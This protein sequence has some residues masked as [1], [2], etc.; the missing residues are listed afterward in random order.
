MNTDYRPTNSWDF[1][2][3]AAKVG[4]VRVRSLAALSLTVALIALLATLATF[5]A[6][7][8]QAQSLIG[9]VDNA[10]QIASSDSDDFQAQSFETG[11]NVGGYTVSQVQIQLDDVSGKSTSVKIRQDDGGEPGNLVATL[12]NPGTL[13]SYQFNTFTAQPVITLAASTTYWITVNEGI[14]SDR[15]PVLNTSGD[16]DSSVWGW[17]IGDDRLYRTSEMDPWSESTRSLLIRIWGTISTDAKL[18]SLTLEGADGGETIAL[19]PAFATG[20]Y[21]YTAAV[22]NR[23]DAVKLTATKND[24]NATV[25]ITNDDDP[26][27][28]EEALLD[29]SVGSNTLTVTVTAQDGTPLTYTINVE[30][31]TTTT[32]LVSNT[33]LSASASTTSFTAQS[34]ETGANTGGYTVSEVDMRLGLASGR[35]ASV[36]IREN[37]ADNEPGDLVATLTNPGTL[38]D[39]SLNTFTAPAGTTLAASTTYWITVNEGISSNRAS[40]DYAEGNG[41]TGETGWS[42]GDDRLSRINETDSWHTATSSL[43][44]TIKGTAVPATTLV[45][46]THLTPLGN[47]GDYEAQ[48]FETGTNA[49]GYTVSGIDMQLG[50]ASGYSTTVKIRENNADNEPGDLVATLTN[51]GTLTDNSLN[52]FTAPAG[53]RLDASTTYW[54]SVNE[55]IPTVSAAVFE[56]S[57]GNAETGEAGWTIGDSRLTRVDETGSWQTDGD[58][59]LITIKGTAVPTTTLVSNTHLSASLDTVHFQAQ[60]FETGANPD[61]Y[62]V[63]EVD[64]R[65]GIV[66]SRSTSVKIRQDD[67]GEPGDL[68]ATLTNPASLKS[69]RLNTFTAPAGTTLAASTTYWITVNEGLYILDSRAIVQANAGNDQTGETGW[70][71]GNDRL[72]R[73]VET[74]EWQTSTSSLLMTIKGTAVPCDGIWCATL[75]VQGLGSGHR[76]CG[77]SSTGNE[78]SNAA[79]L[80]EDEFTHASTPYSVTAARVQSG[81]QLQL[82]L[83]PDITTDSQTLVL[84]VGSETFSFEDATMKEANHRKWNNSGLSWTTGD[85]VQLRLTDSQTNLS[86]SPTISGTPQVGQVLT[87]DISTIDDVDGLPDTFEYQWVRV[88]SDDTKTNLGTNSTHT[89]TSSDVGSTIRVDVSYTDLAGNSEGPLPS[90]ATAA[91]VPAAGLC[92]PNNDWCA[93]MTVTVGKYVGTNT[94]YGFKER[95]FGQLDEPTIDYGPSFEV[96]EIFISEPDSSSFDDLVYVTLDAY[97]PLGTVFNLGG[98]DFT[99]K[100]RQQNQFRHPFLDPPRGLRLDRWPGSHGQREPGPGSG[101]RHRGRDNA[102]HHPFRGPQHGLGPDDKRVHREGGRQRNDAIER[103]GR[104]QDG[105]AHPD[106]AGHPRRDGHGQIPCASEQSLTGHIGPGGA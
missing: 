53:T 76:G 81:G 82:Y 11:A 21:A 98:T 70:S 5:L 101:E 25:V 91:V 95:F 40:V 34:F 104:H 59:L 18:K 83:S 49:G 63:S 39:N 19:S 37:N 8:L 90:E 75:T 6:T 45:S 72:L 32:T 105:D 99:A 33:H 92:P 20:K 50:F 58:S 68:V 87:A 65:F 84:H 26:A 23:I 2:L 12:V 30:R 96:D 86:G 3:R 97:V 10:T 13:T 66:A 27:T 51:P 47:A 60:S 29:L 44:M 14:S 79:H 16:G 43:L 52:T 17:S 73:T 46:N 100:R 9:F 85:T 15:I 78:C 4:G 42:I 24:D 64:I 61:G 7:P 1:R 106:D 36:K 41:E 22:V 35:S 89:V 88:A 94:F 28:R 71:I 56:T 103:V 80:S 93:T 62:T 54:I 74:N 38:T 69:N 55:G 57:S 48:T 67:G 102:G 31:H 77:N